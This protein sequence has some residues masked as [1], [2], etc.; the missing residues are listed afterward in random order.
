MGLPGLLFGVLRHPIFLILAAL[1][2][3]WS[4]VAV[5]N[6]GHQGPPQKPEVEILAR[7]ALSVVDGDAGAV[8]IFPT[9]Q[10]EPIR[11]YQAGEGSFFRGVMR[12]LVR[13]RVARSMD[14][15]TEFVLELTSAGGLI[16]I[17]ELTGYWIAIE[18]F[19]PDN[20]QEFRLIFDR[21]R[22][23]SSARAELS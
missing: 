20:Y 3:A 6:E 22:A 2:L 12:T 15:K 4:L 18:A 7:V 5:N 21:A 1:G 23:S 19:G 16:L 8:M 14:S 11:K 17:D 10:T 13:E 9:G